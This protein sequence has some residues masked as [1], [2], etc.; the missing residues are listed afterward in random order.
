MKVDQLMKSLGSEIDQATALMKSYQAKLKKNDE[1]E[2]KDSEPKDPTD[3]EPQ[4]A[5]QA[6]GQEPAEGTITPAEQQVIDAAQQG[7][8]PDAIKSYAKGLQQE[9]LE[10]IL[11]AL[12]DEMEARDGQQSMPQEGQAPASSPAP[13]MAEKAAAPTQMVFD[14]EGSD[15]EEGMEDPAHEGTESPAQEG[16]EHAP[17]ATPDMAD[18]MG[19]EQP[20]PTTQPAQEPAVGEQGTMSIEDAVSQLSD[21]ELAKIKA[22]ID[23]RV[24]GAAP[25]AAPQAPMAK[26]AMFNTKGKPL[27]KEVSFNTKMQ[28]DTKNAQGSTKSEGAPSLL[29]S[30]NSIVTK[31]EQ[32]I[33]QGKPATTYSDS[34]IKVLEKSER[35]PLYK[36]GF[37]VANRLLVE[38]KKGNQLVKSQMVAEANTCPQEKLGE[39][40]D[41]CR[42]SG[43]EL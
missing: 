15:Q 36:S 40:I 43:V 5:P 23:A 10:A 34:N 6:E 3:A 41:K 24:G 38:Q 28:A 25:V 39:F 17:E 1:M 9:E 13:E 37:E 2:D 42:K 21:E 19:G 12:M 27:N 30:M 16:A 7:E 26:N 33:P 35:E 11:E 4:E 18:P 22:A 20:A 32:L 14:S 31:M 29:K 8:S